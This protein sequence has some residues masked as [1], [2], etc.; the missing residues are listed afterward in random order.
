ML[1]MRARF[2]K[3]DNLKMSSMVPFLFAPVPSS[4]KIVGVISEHVFGF[5]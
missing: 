3:Y 5:W 1:I 4:W 2:L